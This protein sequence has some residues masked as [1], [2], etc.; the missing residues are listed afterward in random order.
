MTNF[1]WPDEL[2]WIPNS[3]IP[4]HTCTET[5]AGKTCVVT[6][7]TSGIGLEG[8]R[9]FASAHAHI[10]IIARNPE[11][12]KLVSRELENI[13]G[14]R[15]G[16]IIS[17]FA[18]LDSVYKAAQSVLSICDKVDVLVNCAGVYSTKKIITPAGHEL[19]FCVNHLAS[20]LF[21]SLLLDRMKKSAPSRILQ[22]NSEGHRFASVDP[23]D[24]DWSR[25]H[26]S[27][28]RAYGQSK[29]AQ[30][31]TTWEFND[32]LSDTGVTINAIH[33]GEVKTNMGMNN[34]KV[35]KIF[36]R[37]LIRP[38]CKS[39]SISGQAL[40]WHAASHEMDGISGNFYNLT[41]IEK[42]A[43]HALNRNL[44]KIV[45]EKSRLLCGL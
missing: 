31:L 22:V 2:K 4:P 12:A 5:M 34:G 20:F 21:T 24:L 3:K 28:L 36:S 29:T 17:D 30:L 6:G 43:D 44:G 25:R 23:S 16:I 38:F 32:R 42:P 45:W 1:R 11:K 33:P 19:T 35:Y 37:Y 15:I 41:T 10:V 18:Y 40:Y 13:S 14:N 39:P 26:Y 7:A 8:A 9:K 27:G